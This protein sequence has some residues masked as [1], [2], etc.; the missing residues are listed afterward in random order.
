MSS[1]GSDLLA[2]ILKILATPEYDDLAN[3]VANIYAFSQKSSA[4]SSMNSQG[5]E[6]SV[7]KKIKRND[8][9][10]SEAQ[11][12]QSKNVDTAYSKRACMKIDG[13]KLNI[14]GRI[15]SL[16]SKETVFVKLLFEK[17]NIYVPTDDL[18]VAV[19][20]GKAG[21]WH[22]SSKKEK[23]RFYSL[24]VNLRKKLPKD[25]LEGKASK[26]YML[27][28]PA[29]ISQGSG[30]V[31]SSTLKLLPSNISAPN[32]S[33]FSEA[34][35]SEEDGGNLQKIQ[36]DREKYPLIG[37]CYT[38]DYSKFVKDIESIRRRYIKVGKSPG[39]VRIGEIYVSFR[40]NKFTLDGDDVF[41]SPRETQVLRFL[42]LWYPKIVS[43]E[44]IYYNLSFCVNEDYAC[45][46][47]SPEMKIRYT[48]RLVGYVKTRLRSVTD[49]IRVRSN[50]KK[51]YKLVCYSNRQACPNESSVQDTLHSQSTGSSS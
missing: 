33:D 8:A 27:S 44:Q 45:S 16:G 49:G 2:E 14:N 18:Y 36:Y 46:D 6:P 19:Y 21:G 28:D 4:E 51:G 34:S 22:K 12:A 26:G 20:G 25:C 31:A 37:N 1:Q 40:E 10:S 17:R 13:R 38:D 41:L 7:R 35:E 23:K 47:E 15:I 50:R 5:S 9:E 30:F 32:D 42:A 11:Q 39:F 3:Q 24:L 43:Y 48:T 29:M